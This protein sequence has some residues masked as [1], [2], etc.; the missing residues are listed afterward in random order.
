[1]CC[2]P[3][4]PGLYTIPRLLSFG[5]FGREWDAY[6]IFSSRMSTRHARMQYREHLVT[7]WIEVSW[8]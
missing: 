3:S 2:S 6:G 8:P 4:P 1:L 7:A 5:L